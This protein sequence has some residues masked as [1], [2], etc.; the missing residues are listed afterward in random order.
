MKA[1][2]GAIVVLGAA[3]LAGASLLAIAVKESQI[4]QDPTYIVVIPRENENFCLSVALIM[5][6]VGF[7]VFLRNAVSRPPELPRQQGW[8]QEPPA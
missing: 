2:A 6:V 7:A 1:I 3:I 4:S 8:P 5:G